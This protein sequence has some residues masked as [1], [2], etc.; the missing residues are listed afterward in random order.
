[1]MRTGTNVRREEVPRLASDAGRFLGAGIVN[2]VL[3]LVA[4]QLLLF[5][6]S[7]TVA[8]AIT[9]VLGIAFVALVYPSRVFQGG[10][11]TPAARMMTVAVYVF[12]FGI[13]VAVIQ[14]LTITFGMERIAIL[15]A[16]AV[17]TCFNFLAMRTV[18][19]ARQAKS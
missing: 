12:S 19:R 6:F 4:Y 13:G 17:T 7:A 14:L 3:T 9:W 11:N 1:M 16:L 15:A 8:Y 10:R 18:L 2:T 5:V